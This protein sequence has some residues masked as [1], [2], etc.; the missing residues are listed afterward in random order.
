MVCET[1]RRELVNFARVEERIQRAV[2]RGQVLGLA[3]AVVE[4]DTITV[5]RGFGITSVEPE[6]VPI[7]PTTLFCAAS[8]SKTI[9]ATAV[10]RLVD[11]GLL[12]LDQPVLRYLPGFALSNPDFGARVTLRHLLSHTSGLAAGGKD[13]GSP[14]RDALERFCDDQLSRYTFIAEPGRVHLYSNTAICLAGYVLEVVTRT[15]YRD[16]VAELVFEPLRMTRSTYDHAVAMTHRVALA[17]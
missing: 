3:L 6:G 14:E 15:S 11:R 1:L 16:L 9:L 7:T 10:M 12:D 17:H 4:G 13:W 8:L 5:A 2:E